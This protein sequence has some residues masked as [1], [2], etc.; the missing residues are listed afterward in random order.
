[1]NVPCYSANA[2]KRVQDVTK[3]GHTTI[4]MTRYIFL[5]L[6]NDAI[7]FRGTLVAC[8]FACN[9]EIKDLSLIEALQRLLEPTFAKIQ[10]KENHHDFSLSNTSR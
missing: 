6:S 5:L 7:M 1:M 2:K 4:V 8:F 3:V 10:S 9:A